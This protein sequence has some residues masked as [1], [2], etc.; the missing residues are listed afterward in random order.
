LHIVALL[1]QSI[2]NSKF[3]KSTLLMSFKLSG[4]MMA[5]KWFLLDVIWCVIQEF[6][7]C[8]TEFVDDG[9]MIGSNFPCYLLLCKM[10]DSCPADP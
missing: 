6:Q 9:F 1:G 7:A 10:L 3:M 8:C 2:M 4:A 5:M